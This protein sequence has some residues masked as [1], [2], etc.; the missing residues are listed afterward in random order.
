[1]G[2]SR[3][4]FLM[5]VGQ[6]GGYSAAFAT[7]Q[8]L[9]LVPMK[10]A[11]AE[12]IQAAAGSGKGVK[13]VVLGGGI[14]GL[15]SAYELQKLGYDVTLLEAS[16]RPGGRNWTGR[17]GTEVCFCDGSKQPI[18]W[19]E[20]NY[21]NLGP[22]RLP[23][24]H[25]TMLGYCREL[26]IPLEVEVNTSRSTLLQ[27]DSANGGKPVPQR[28]AINDTRGH[29]SELLSK[30]IAHG[31]L[32]AE[33]SK[34]DRERMTAFLKIYGPLD[35]KGA[36]V[37]SDRAG[38]KTPP[39][40]GTQA[41]VDDTPMDMRVLLDENF[42][43][44]L[45]VEEAWDWQATMMQPVGG[46]DRIPY[47]FAKAL[48]PVVQF[49]SPVT[50]IR[51][52]TKGVRVS[53]TQGGAT[54]QVEASYCIIAIP[55]SMLKKIP[56][57]LSKPFKTVVD[58]STMGGAYKIAWESR[59]F[60]E[61][62]YNIYGGL[63]YL[64]EGPSPIWYP[65]SRLM[66]PTGVVVSGYSD[67]L[68]TPFYDLTLAQKLEASRASI[69]KL[70]PGHGNELKNPVFCGWSRVPWN[71]GSWINSYGGGKSGYDTIIQADGPIYFAGDTASHIV[72]WQ[73]GA[74]MSGRRAV[75]M[76]SD[77]VK[78]AKLSGDPAGAV[79]S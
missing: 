50:E 74:A 69:E 24:V 28:K 47:A 42:W 43:D 13:V 62:D 60:W 75:G 57:D 14:G 54:K 3:R 11:Q 8:S 79:M 31:S 61:Q 4:N 36:Y 22:A 53:Y 12:T 34:E 33:L 16:A 2:I 5:R 52:T 26:G 58:E 63:S 10:G 45:F 35:D 32:D 19:E 55:F 37:G 44:D 71:E 49:N 70:H 23:S 29:V 18:Q 51:K 20:G 41:G 72:G 30:C 9:G 77:K 66:H 7:M 56:N 6:V 38:Y 73:E 68:G 59:R 67:E 15:V 40:A 39:G 48:G 64:M 17:N 25:W 46:M 65:S 27:N 78:M 76:I 21:Q 1:M